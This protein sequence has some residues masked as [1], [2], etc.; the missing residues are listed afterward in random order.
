MV[1]TKGFTLVELLAVVLI[2]AIALCCIGPAVSRCMNHA[3]ESIENTRQFH[4]QRIDAAWDGDTPNEI[5]A[6]HNYKEM[7]DIKEVP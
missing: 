6:C 3:R 4:A 2:M 5:F 1:K 7:T